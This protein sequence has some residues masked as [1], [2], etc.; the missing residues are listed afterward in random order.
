MGSTPGC[1]EALGPVLELVCAGQRVTPAAP[2]CWVL[3]GVRQLWVLWGWGQAGDT[4]QEV[5][6]AWWVTG[7]FLQPCHPHGRLGPS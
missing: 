7:V 4:E 5:E 3:A 2:S 6:V 1:E